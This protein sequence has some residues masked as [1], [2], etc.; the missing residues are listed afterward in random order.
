MSTELATAAAVVLERTFALANVPA[1][2]GEEEQ[3]GQAV[4]AWWRQDGL[5]EAYRDDAGNVWVRVRAGVPGFEAALICAHLDTVFG[6]EV[7]HGVVEAN[8]RLTGPSVGDNT[9]AVCALT[10]LDSLLPQKALRHPVWLVATVGEE[11]LGNLA[12]I[13]A[14]LADPPCPVGVVIALEGNYL[15]RVNVV[16][17][18]S[19]RWRVTVTG[20][21]GHAWEDAATPSAVHAVARVITDLDALA[22]HAR[23]RAAVN[24]GLVEGGETVN[25]RAERCSFV[26]DLR[27]E[28]PVTLAALRVRAR[29]AIDA[30]PAPLQ[31]TVDEIG[32]RPAGRLDE[33]HQL[34]AI[35]ASVLDEAGIRPRFTA[36]S[37]DAN[38]AY[39]LNIPAVTLGVTTGGGTHTEQ[40]WI[41]VEPISTGLLTLT[42]TIERL[43]EQDW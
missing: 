7:K 35:A 6:H 27:S 29:E 42:R 5:A 26:L 23:P 12:G 31:V 22:D 8:G 18:G 16:G 3:R 32:D 9:V 14:A 10:V 30:V 34:A 13:R 17:V 19:V 25:S 38:A 21:G 39:A 36:A 2:S 33:E 15:G 40:E 41:D 37:T 4:L 11:G 20:P 24:V 28:D 43:D 1:P